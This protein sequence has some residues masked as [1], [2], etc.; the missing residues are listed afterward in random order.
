M[1]T[2]PVN[3]VG[4]G[5]KVVISIIPDVRPPYLTGKSE[6]WNFRMIN[7]VSSLKVEKMPKKLIDIKKT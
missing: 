7:D 6:K 2:S 4:V 5:S 3:F 1:P